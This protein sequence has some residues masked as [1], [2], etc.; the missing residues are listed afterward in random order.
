MRCVVIAGLLALASCQSMAQP[1][2]SPVPTRHPPQPRPTAS[3]RAARLQLDYDGW[4]GATQ[5]VFGYLRIRDVSA[6]ACRLSGRIRVSG[7]DANDGRVTESVT[8]KISRPILLTPKAKRT[9]PHSPPP[10]GVR[11]AGVTITGPEF[12]PTGGDCSPSVQPTAFRVAVAG[13]VLH[14]RDVRADNNHAFVTCHGKLSGLGR[15]HLVRR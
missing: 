9:A 2:T 12:G 14:A 5:N 13:E 10:K 15:V 11:M 6:S 3:C 1:L 7:V 4:Q 8:F